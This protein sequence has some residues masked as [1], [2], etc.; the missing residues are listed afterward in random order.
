MGPLLVHGGAH[1]FST[2]TMFYR[3]VAKPLLSR[4][5]GGGGISLTIE[6]PSGWYAVARDVAAAGQI[7]VCPEPRCPVGRRRWA[8]LDDLREHRLHTLSRLAA[9]A[10]VHDTPTLV[11]MLMQSGQSA[12]AAYAAVLAERDQRAA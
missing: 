8:S 9:Q 12:M 7:G 6:A 4:G 3:T 5:G 11:Q 1:G 10:A 2:G